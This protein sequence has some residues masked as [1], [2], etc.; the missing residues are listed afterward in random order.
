MLT[1]SHAH[2]D[3]ERLQ[4]EVDAVIARAKEAGVGLI[5]SVG[6]DLESSRRCIGLAGL[7]DCVYAVAGVHPHEAAQAPEGYLDEL[8]SLLTAPK[9]VALG[10]IGLDYHYD[11]SPRPVQQAVFAAQLALARE[12]DCAVVVHTR[13]ADE[14]TYRILAESGVRRVVLHC[15]SGNWEQAQRYL[16][17]GYYLS[18]SGVVT[19]PKSEDTRE[20][21]ANVPLNRLMLETDAPYLAPVPRRGRRNEP[22]YVRHTAEAV[23]GLRG[24]ALEDLAR[25]TTAN[26]RRFFGIK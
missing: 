6:S 17:L 18:L 9:V 25:E 1:D 20:V 2:L 12:L 22:A 4:G 15:F 14:D 10:E 21:A 19:F 5:V 13:E 7:Y 11:L 26:V 24:V 23:A 16:E 8:R 3:D